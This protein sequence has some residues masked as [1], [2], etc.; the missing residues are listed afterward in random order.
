MRKGAVATLSW[1]EKEAGIF[2]DLNQM[3]IEDAIN[4]PPDGKTVFDDLNIHTSWK[5]RKCLN[6]SDD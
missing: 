6:Q 2:Q 3:A 5:M 4:G 1:A